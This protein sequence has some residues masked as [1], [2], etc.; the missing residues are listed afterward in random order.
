MRLFQLNLSTSSLDSLLQVLSFLL[1]Q[2]F[3]HS[4]GGTVNQILSF[5]QAKTASF[6]HSLNNLQLSSTC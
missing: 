2:A 3:L 5:L 4:S 6:L 1:R